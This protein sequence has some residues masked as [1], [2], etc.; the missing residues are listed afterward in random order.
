VAVAGGADE[1]G[2]VAG[3]ASPRPRMAGG[4]GGDSGSCRPWK[5]RKMKLSG[6]VLLATA[7]RM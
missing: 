5:S 3:A 7:P 4:T 2:P 6:G 1:A